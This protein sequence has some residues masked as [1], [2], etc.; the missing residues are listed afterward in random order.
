MSP[1]VWTQKCENFTVGRAF[2]EELVERT[3]TPPAFEIDVSTAVTCHVVGCG[4]A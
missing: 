3:E 4:P 1:S 2:D